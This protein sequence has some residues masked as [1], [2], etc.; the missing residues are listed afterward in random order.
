MKVQSR[1]ALGVLALLVG[2]ATAC[3]PIV[4]AGAAEPPK[5]AATKSTSK[6]STSRAK[7]AP[8]TPPERKPWSLRNHYTLTSDGLCLDYSEEDA[9]WRIIVESLTDERMNLETLA[10]DVGFSVELE[11]GR[12][13][14][15]DALGRAGAQCARESF[16][17][18]VLGAGTHYTTTFAP[19]E[20]LVIWH[21]L[22]SFQGFPFWLIRVGIRNDG[23][24]PRGIRRVTIARFNAGSIAGLG[25]DTQTTTRCLTAPGGV[26]RPDPKGSPTFMQF[27]APGRGI[28]IVF[29]LIPAGRG[30]GRVDLQPAGGAWQGSIEMDCAP[31]CRIAPGETLESDD[32]FISIGKLPMRAVSDYGWLLSMLNWPKTGEK[33][34]RAW[35]TIPDTE[36]FNVLKS[37]AAAAASAGI[38]YALVPWNWEGVPGSLEG[39]APGYPRD[40]SRVAKELSGAGV[41]PGITVDPL[42]IQGGNDAWAVSTDDGR[43]WVNPTHPDGAAYITERMRKLIRQG[44]GFVVVARSQIPDVAL[45]HFG[46]S[47]EEAWWRAIGAAQAA[48]DGIPVYPETAPEIK[49]Q[50]DALLEAATLTAVPGSYHAR[51]AAV[52]VN[53][54]GLGNALDEETALALRLWQ[55]PVELLWSG[56]V[57]DQQAARVAAA[58]NAPAVHGQPLTLGGEVPLRW[59]ARLTTPSGAEFGR[60][61]L[62]FSGA[63]AWNWP[64]ELGLGPAGARLCR[65]NQEGKIEVA[66]E[67]IPATGA[68]T[69]WR[70]LTES[71]DPQVMGILPDALYGMDWLS[72]LNWDAAAGTL[73]G[74]ITGAGQNTRLYVQLGSG[75]SVDGVKRGGSRVK[76]ESDGKWL[77]FPVEG[78]NG[79]EIR[80]TPRAAASGT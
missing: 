67:D 58:L 68:F 73:T 16:T 53:F 76:F 21:R 20:G 6:K 1:F 65:L 13:L 64:K 24:Q 46:V 26:L 77:A 71:A 48:G 38:R 78:G 32:L 52:R 70:I 54:S 17:H 63:E 74:V 61:V 42:L 51:L 10:R 27:T 60:A 19:S 56:R 79:F 7:K 44:F 49:P 5:P 80:V 11:D 25:D 59:Q 36:G 34:P 41:T 4:Q 14:T 69:T 66:A 30:L 57:P 18:P 28:G 12:V 23:E 37:A 72:R 9:E 75:W 39:G 40:I 2:L 31:V 55:G 8:E 43:R 3:W 35:V 45:A 15:H 29:A 22:S 33:A 47:R 50:R 62:L